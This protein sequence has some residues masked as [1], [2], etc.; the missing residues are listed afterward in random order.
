MDEPK[1]ETARQTIVT[2][3]PLTLNAWLRWD[4]IREWVDA[5]RPASILEIGAGAG[6][7]G[8]RLATMA[9]TYVGFE[10]DAVSRAIAA[11]RMPAGTSLVAG[12]DELGDRTFALVCAFEVI[13]HIDD[14]RAV[15]ASWVRRVEDD[16]WLMLS[17]PAFAAKLG[18]WDVRVGHHRRYDPDHLATMLADAGLVDIEVRVVGFPLGHALEAARNAIARRRPSADAMTDRTAGSGR[19]LQPGKGDRATEVLTAPFRLVQRR[20][21]DRGTTLVAVARRPA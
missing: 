10:P 14:D 20:F 11:E 8:A 16:G 21:P 18:A 2:Q 5:I 19:L 4:V 1:A 3:A 15:L 13:E 9:P 6:A 7:A 17:T 12:E